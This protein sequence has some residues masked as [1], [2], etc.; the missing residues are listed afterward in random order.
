MFV[1]KKFLCAV[2][3]MV[4]IFV[5]S[6]CSNNYSGKKYDIQKAGTEIV[7]QIESAS[8]MTQVNDDI[9]M[10]FYGIDKADVNDY[11]ALISTD[12]TKQD[13][14]IIAEAK[15]SQSFE[16]IKEKIQTR[17]DSK[18][19]QTKDYLPEEAKLIEECKI[20]TD[21]NYVW[22]FISADAEKMKEIL[23]STAE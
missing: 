11:F 12:S 21:G 1:L 18:Y 13:E 19:A 5:F 9:L 17:Y 2:V 4:F 15:D 10:S 22:M 8:H 3:S 23:L 6:G 16:K 20:E 14:V 7:A